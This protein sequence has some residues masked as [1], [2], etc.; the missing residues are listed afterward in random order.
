MIGVTAFF[1]ASLAFVIGVLVGGGFTL[2]TLLVLR[3][4]KQTNKLK[5]WLIGAGFGLIVWIPVLILHNNFS[6]D[7][8]PQAEDFKNMFKLFGMI[9]LTP[10]ILLTAG[11]LGQLVGLI[12]NK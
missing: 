7:G 9:G 11:S 4:K 10:G 12:K 5:F 2:T 1:I 8:A 6:P 3:A